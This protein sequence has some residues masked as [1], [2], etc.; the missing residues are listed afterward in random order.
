[1]TMQNTHAS[2]F[3]GAYFNDA[4]GTRKGYMGWINTGASLFGPG[5]MQIGTLQGGT[6]AAYITM[7]SS[8]GNVGIGTASPDFKLEVNGDAGKPGGGFWSSSSD[9]RLKDVQGNFT[10]GLE[11]LEALQPI[12]YNYKP[13]NSLGLPSGQQYV[14]VIAQEVQEMIPEAVETGRGDYLFVNN[15]AILWTMLNAIKELKAENDVLKAQNNAFEERFAQIEAALEKMS[16]DVLVELPS[17]KE[18]ARLE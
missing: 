5:S 9:R 10:R 8:T 2:G 13:D 1:M 15:E 16:D 18:G 3:A 6:D 4:D 7:K 14:G 11:A 17:A 12:Y